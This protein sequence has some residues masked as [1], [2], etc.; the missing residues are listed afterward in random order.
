MEKKRVSLVMYNKRYRDANL[1]CIVGSTYQWE[2]GL[3]TLEYSALVAFISGSDYIEYTVELPE[4][5]V[6]FAAK[7]L[8]PSQIV[9]FALSV[10]NLQ[11]KVAS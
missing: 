5:V 6:A 11:K 8:S 10:N 7:Q 9:L 2:L 3:N 4:Q 1:G